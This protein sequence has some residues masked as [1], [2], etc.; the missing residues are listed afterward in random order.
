M[1]TAKTIFVFLLFLSSPVLHAAT[2][3]RAGILDYFQME[4]SVRP[5]YEN[6]LWIR[7]PGSWSSSVN[8][9]GTYAYIH[10]AQDKNLVAI[11]LTARI[12]DRPVRMLVD[13]ALAKIDGTF[14]RVISI[15]MP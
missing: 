10:A 11:A 1:K 13:D 7:Q 8:C 6:V 5:G 4:S 12:M 2:G 14:C 15:E 9:A 3:D